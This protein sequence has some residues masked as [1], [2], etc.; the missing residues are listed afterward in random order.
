MKKTKKMFYGSY[1]TMLVFICQQSS[2]PFYEKN[3]EIRKIS[4]PSFFPL[5]SPHRSAFS[6]RMEPPKPS[7]SPDIRDRLVFIFLFHDLVLGLLAVEDRVNIR[8]S[9][10]KEYTCHYE[11][12]CPEHDISLGQPC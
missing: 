8:A 2:L 12:L 11:H 5:V 3:G 10:Y 1:T 4:P 6:V 9:D 7:D